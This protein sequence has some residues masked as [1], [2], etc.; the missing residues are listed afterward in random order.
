LPLVAFQHVP[1][2]WGASTR[3]AV[4]AG[5]FWGTVGAVRELLNQQSSDLGSDRWVIW[6]GGDADLLAGVI[7]DAGARVEPDLVLLGLR[8]ELLSSLD[9]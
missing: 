1:P 4:E 6:T 7:A 2:Y 5:V 8:S 3:P 9:Q